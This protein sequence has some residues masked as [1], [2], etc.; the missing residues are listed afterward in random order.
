VVM[1]GADSL[2]GF[3][4]NRFRD[5]SSVLV[6]VEYRYQ[7]WSFMDVAI[8]ADWGGVFG[9]R[10]GGIEPHF[11]DYKSAAFDIIDSH[12]RDATALTGLFLLLDIATFIAL[13]L[14]I[15]LVQSGQRHTLDAHL[16][17]GLSFLQLGLRYLQQCCYLA[18]PL[19]PLEPL[20]P[21]NPPPACASRSKRKRLDVQIQFSRITTF[22]A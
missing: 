10:F 15:L 8:F 6:T 12:L 18:N 17:R 13:I 19:P 4:W 16:E 2:R 21:Q 11:K 5:H 20:P 1:G 9:K 22:S 14:G 3:G 7:V